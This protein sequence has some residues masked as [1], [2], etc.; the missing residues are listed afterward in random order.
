MSNEFVPTRS[1][2]LITKTKIT[3]A[4]SGLPKARLLITKVCF[5]AAPDLI[6]DDLFLDGKA[7]GIQALQTRPGRFETS[8]EDASFD[9]WIKYYRPDENAI[10]NQISYYDKGEIVNMLLDIRIR[11][12]SGGAKS[13]DDVMRYM[14]NEFFKKGKNYAPA[15]YQKAAEMMAGASLEDFFDKYVRGTDDIN[16]NEILSGVGLKLND[17][18]TGRKQAYLGANLAESNGQ[19][20]ISSVPAGTPAYDYGLNA[21]DQIVAI[22][23][24][25]ASMTF[26][27]EL[28]CRKE[29]GR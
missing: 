29:T 14:Y 23:G 21:K 20:N 27:D 19:L 16:Y 7:T 8:L 26:F 28:S 4:R 11:T 13:L 15:D 17:E 25:R 3:R 18:E 10:N 9:A 24:N 22:D 1:D 6:S 5:C 2:R 12:L